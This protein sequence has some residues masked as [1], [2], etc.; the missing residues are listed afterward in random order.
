MNES[1]HG[2]SRPL[3][4]SVTANEGMEGYRAPEILDDGRYGSVADMYT[5]GVIIHRLMS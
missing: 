4:L 5:L 1:D 3:G 2:L